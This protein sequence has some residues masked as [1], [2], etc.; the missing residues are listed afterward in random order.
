MKGGKASKYWFQC[1]LRLQNN[2]SPRSWDNS[3]L[4]MRILEEGLDSSFKVFT[5]QSTCHPA[6]SALIRKALIWWIWLDIVIIIGFGKEWERVYCK[7]Q[8]LMESSR[9]YKLLHSDSSDSSSSS[10]SLSSASPIVFCIHG[11][12]WGVANCCEDIDYQNSAEHEP[13]VGSKPNIT[14]RDQFPADKKKM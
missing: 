1:H 4:Q 9:P 13:M 14:K 7:K 8:V 11:N 2:C 5:H 3:G 10:R 6:C 12:K